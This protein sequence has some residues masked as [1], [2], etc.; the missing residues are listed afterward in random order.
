[1]SGVCEWA[2]VR[3]LLLGERAFVGMRESVNT[4]EHLSGDFNWGVF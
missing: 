2:F 3:E 1:M 4:R